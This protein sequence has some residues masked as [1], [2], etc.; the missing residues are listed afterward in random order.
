MKTEVVKIDVNNIEKDKLI[1][2]AEIIKNGGLVAFPTETVYGLGANALNSEAVKKI[3]KAKGRP[4]DNPLIVHIADIKS[5]DKL[6]VEMPCGVQKL[7][8]KFWP[9]PLTLVFKKSP[10]IP[11]EITAGLDTI[12]IRMPSHPI[13][14]ALI[15]EAGLPIAAPS[16]NSSGRPSPT[17]AS[18]VLEDLS[19]KINLIIDGGSTHVGLEST[20]LDTTSFPPSILRPGGVTLEQLR[21]VLGEVELDPDLVSKENL[22]SEGNN[23]NATPKS[24]GV[25][26]K[27]YSPKAK[28]VIVEGE[29]DKVVNKINKLI[30]GYEKEGIRVGVLA[31][32]QTKNFYRSPVVISM[33]D[34]NH[35]DIIASNLFNCFREFD[36][37]NIQV[38]F[39]EAIDKTGIGL[40][41]MNRMNKAAGYNI[42]RL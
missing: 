16:A 20:V 22:I 30:I 3:F 31:T 14:L 32:D 13:A 2:A 12:A 23:N 9:G 42:I 40:A 21:E 10:V 24:P 37:L 5:I 33:G 7:I 39:A 8:D 26:Y 35:P 36:H 11:D 18:H 29:L 6:V 19:G 17:L 38:I 25:K 28:L 15:K 4:L 34:R 27:H 1:Y 41:V